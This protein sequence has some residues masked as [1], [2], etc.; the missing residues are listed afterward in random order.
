M[1]L[2][3]VAAGNGKRDAFACMTKREREGGREC[4]AESGD[5]A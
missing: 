1:L 5:S 4:E 2:L 3:L